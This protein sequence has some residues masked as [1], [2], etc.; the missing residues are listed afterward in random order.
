MKLNDAQT[1]RLLEY[2]GQVQIKQLSLNMALTRL[3]GRYKANPTSGT[4]STCTAELN[5][6]FDKF[7]IIMK[8]DYE[9]VVGL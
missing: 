3:R 1:K 2:T 4:I 8:P 9:W 5:A 6:L 7:A